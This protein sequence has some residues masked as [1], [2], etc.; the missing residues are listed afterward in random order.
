MI[1]SSGGSA[2]NY[3]IM[4]FTDHWVAVYSESVRKLKITKKIPGIIRIVVYVLVVPISRVTIKHLWMI[5]E[6]NIIIISMWTDN[7]YRFESL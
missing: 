6:S 1:T 2:Q 3:E 7:F 4:T 5:I